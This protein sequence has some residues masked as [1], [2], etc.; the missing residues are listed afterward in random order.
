MFFFP[1]VEENFYE[2]NKLLNEG[3]PGRFEGTDSFFEGE[4]LHLSILNIG[5]RRRW[6]LFTI[7]ILLFLEK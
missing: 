5:F 1:A 3:L 2:E 6:L 4:C 7:I